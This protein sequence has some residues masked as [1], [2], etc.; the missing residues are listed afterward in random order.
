VRTPGRPPHFPLA[1]GVRRIRRRSGVGRR[2]PRARG[3]H[4]PKRSTWSGPAEGGNGQ[5]GL[6]RGNVWQVLPATRV[7]PIACSRRPGHGGGRRPS[8]PGFS[9]PALEWATSRT[10]SASTL[11]RAFAVGGFESCPPRGASCNPGVGRSSRPVGRQGDRI[12]AWWRASART[13]P[14]RRSTP[15]SPRSRPAP[16]RPRSG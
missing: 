2:H 4:Q 5:V 9:V 15:G 7:R 1:E 12:R 11:R 13:L 6:L 3:H 16:A 14:A 10:P 8:G